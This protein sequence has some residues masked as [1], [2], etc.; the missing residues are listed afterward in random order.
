MKRLLSLLLVLAL[1][2]LVVYAEPMDGS[3]RLSAMQEACAFGR[4]TADLRAA[5]DGDLVEVEALVT[6]GL[7]PDAFMLYA[8]AVCV[9]AAQPWPDFT[10]RYLG[11]VETALLREAVTLVPVWDGIEDGWWAVILTLPDRPSYSGAYWAGS[12]ESDTLYVSAFAGH[13]EDGMLW[14]QLMQVRLAEGVHAPIAWAAEVNGEAGAL[15][16]TPDAW[17]GPEEETAFSGGGR[18]GDTL[19]TLRIEAVVED[20]RQEAAVVELLPLAP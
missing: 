6:E 19:K 18:I 1:C 12:M 2:A 9:G 10:G 7:A 14:C 15:M 5:I 4:C 3:G 20:E 8:G 17:D 11:Y 13:T 16:L